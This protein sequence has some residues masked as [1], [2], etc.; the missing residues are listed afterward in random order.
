MRQRITLHPTKPPGP[1]MRTRALVGKDTIR[2]TMIAPCGMNCR[3]CRAYVRQKRK[4]PGCRG[5]DSHKSRACIACQI[6]NCEKIAKAQF[7]YCFACDGFPCAGLKRLSMRYSTRYGVSLIDNLE[8]IGRLGIRQFIKD[9]KE[10]WACPTC[11]QIICVHKPQCLN[12]QH[13]WR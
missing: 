5:G 7:K 3:L 9:E 2:L 8:N 12:C 6:R 11:E 13:T 10:T 1:S 4:C